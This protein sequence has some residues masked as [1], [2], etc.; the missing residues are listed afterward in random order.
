MTFQTGILPRFCQTLTK[1]LYEQRAVHLIRHNLFE[2]G[3]AVAAHND[4]WQQD[5]RVSK[6]VLDMTL[7][8]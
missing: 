3:I 1:K 4:G 8:T 6:N 5:L 2:G 7:K